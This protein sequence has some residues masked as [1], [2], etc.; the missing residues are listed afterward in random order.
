MKI[1]VKNYGAIKEA[2]IRIFNND[3]KMELLF[4]LSGVGKSTL[5]KILQKKE[6]KSW[7]YEEKPE[8]IIDDPSVIDNLENIVVFDEN[9]SIKIVQNDNLD[10]YNIISYGKDAIEIDDSVKELESFAKDIDDVLKNLKTE[11]RYDEKKTI[12]QALRNPKTG[13]NKIPKLHSEV[14]KINSQT[15]NKFNNYLLS[16]INYIKWRE[17]GDVL[18]S[19]DKSTCPYCLEKTVFW[20]V[21]KGT[22]KITSTQLNSYNSVKDMSLPRYDNATLLDN[23][24]LDQLLDRDH[25]ILEQIDTIERVVN[26]QIE[27]VALSGE[28]N[29]LELKSINDV[30]NNKKIDSIVE[31]L[32]K[33]INEF[34]KKIIA[35]SLLKSK[36]ANS[37]NKLIEDKMSEMNSLLKDLN[38]KYKFDFD[39]N[40]KTTEAKYKLI[41]VTKKNHQLDNMLNLSFGEKNILSL[42]LTIFTPCENSLIIFD[43]PISS[44]DDL[45]RNRMIKEIVNT[46]KDNYIKHNNK[47]LVLTHD[48]YFIRQ[49]VFEDQIAK[50]FN[51]QAM[52]RAIEDGHYVFQKVSYNDF[53]TV[54]ESILDQAV[55]YDLYSKLILLRQFCE[56]KRKNTNDL[57]QEY[58][59]ISDLLKLREVDEVIISDTF[60]EGL[61]EG[62]NYIGE[63]QNISTTEFLSKYRNIE[64]FSYLDDM[65]SVDKL[66]AL[67]FLTE[68]YYEYKEEQYHYCLN[69]LTHL[70]S[71]PYKTIDYRKHNIYNI[72][73]T[74]SIKDLIIEKM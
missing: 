61:L 10:F 35:I 55:N 42:I 47:V 59:L 11:I 13:K 34:N 22:L 70:I 31:N 64:S 72:E 73:I 30:S 1:E 4:G 12:L 36:S 29:D 52:Y 48:E 51:I 67:R 46:F 23:D 3:K 2:T 21:P 56:I 66:L 69:D 39:I 68:E 24:S 54:D 41:P 25:Y 20:N 57:K 74:Q 15:S 7:I 43:D 65:N 18:R 45:K 44:F 58:D 16:P 63:D 26:S 71:S 49:V 38:I 50:H 17:Q 37:L 5:V 28:I 6:V 14:E 33:K 19:L 60:F 8:V 53:I 9:E 27:F 62:R 32:N 40:H